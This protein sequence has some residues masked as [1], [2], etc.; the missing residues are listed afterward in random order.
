[1]TSQV[2]QIQKKIFPILQQHH[3]IRA[4][5]FGSLVTG[6]LRADSDIDILVELGPDTSLL[7]LV[8]LK[9]D[10]EDALDR[11]VDLTE[12]PMIHPRLSKRILQEEV[13]VL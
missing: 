9:L 10:L 11:S 8:A 12:Y 3:V 1:M 6:H 7:D 4:G 2:E 13:R 5:L